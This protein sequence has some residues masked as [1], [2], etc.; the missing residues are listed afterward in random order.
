MVL[1]ETFCENTNCFLTEVWMIL[2]I[3]VR[4]ICSVSPV[5]R[6][7]V[8]RHQA[9]DYFDD[10]EEIQLECTVSVGSI[11]HYICEV[12]VRKTSSNLRSCTVQRVLGTG[13][14]I[15]VP[16]SLSG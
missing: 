11:K 3:V 13:C 4:H 15:T 2:L 10:E 9:Y 5:K 16:V 7:T 1:R 12:D 14:E 8:G 6:S